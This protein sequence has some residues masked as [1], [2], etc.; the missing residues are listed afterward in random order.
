MTDDRFEDWLGET[1]RKEYHMPPETPREEMWQAIQARRAAGRTGRKPGRR[2]ARYWTRPVVWIPLAAAA[3]LVLGIGIGRW[4]GQERGGPQ[5]AQ[6]ADTS[7]APAAGSAN[8][9]SARVYQVAATQYLSQAEAFLTA[10][11]LDTAAADRDSS[12]SRDARR[13]LATNRLLL[14]SPAGR[15]ARLKQLLQDLEFTLAEIAQISRGND[16]AA[17]VARGLEQSGILPRL[18]TAVPAGPAVTGL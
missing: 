11:K 16:D 8:L 7:M 4:T 13:L 10:F 12:V 15:D 18:R 5:V 14:D 2:A 6:G 17:Y 1:A 9:G 3:V